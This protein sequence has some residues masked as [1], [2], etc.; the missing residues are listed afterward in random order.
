MSMSLSDSSCSRMLR[1]SCT[2]TLRFFVF[3]G[4]IAADFADVDVGPH[5]GDDLHPERHALLDLDLDDVVLELPFGEV[6]LDLVAVFGERR[7]IWASVCSGGLGLLPKSASRGL[8]L[9]CAGLGPGR[10]LDEA[11][12]GED[13][14]GNTAPA[15]APRGG[16]CAST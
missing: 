16:W 6:A 3:L 9:R 14:L 5:A 7:Q 13:A 1:A 4:R 12:L 11:V 10:Y 15:A 2:G 8:T